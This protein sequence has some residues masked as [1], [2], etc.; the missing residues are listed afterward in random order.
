MSSPTKRVALT[1]DDG[2]N[3]EYT[4]QILEI[5]KAHGIKAAFF[6][7]GRNIER[8]PEIALMAKSR[9]HIIGN[10]TY[11]HPHLNLLITSQ[12][13]LQIERAEEVFEKILDL[14]PRYF[15]PP[16]GEYNNAVEKIIRQKGY[17]LVLWDNDCY[18]MDWLNRSPRKIADISTARAK[19]GS[20]ILLHDGR[21]IKEGAPCHNTVKALRMIITRLKDN[22]F[23]IVTLDKLCRD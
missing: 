1:F 9:G 6:F 21:N 3:G 17:K 13:L 12:A 10:H 16:Y 14:R 7:P 18:S 20:I 19:D 15:R 2:P 22:G 4:L 8:L 5:L 23:D 11:D